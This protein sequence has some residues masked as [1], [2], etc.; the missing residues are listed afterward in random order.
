MT[1][2]LLV[3]GYGSVG[4]SIPYWPFPI[5]FPALPFC[6]MDEIVALTEKY[7]AFCW[8]QI[9]WGTSLEFICPPYMV[10]G[11]PCPPCPQQIGFVNCGDL[12]LS[13]GIDNLIYAMTRWFPDL[14]S[15]VKFFA[16]N[17]CFKGHCG[18][19]LADEYLIHRKYHSTNNLSHARTDEEEPGHLNL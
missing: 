9:W 6:V 7:F 16:E 10:L 1:P 5:A 13:S 18:S 19:L 8:C 2:S 14:T 12:G 17:S 4:I 3:P 15:V 11:D